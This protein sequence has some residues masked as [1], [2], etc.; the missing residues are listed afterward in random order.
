VLHWRAVPTFDDLRGATLPHGL[1]SGN[2]P[3]VVRRFVLTV[4]EPADALASWGSVGDRCSIGS[5]P[6]NDLVIDHKTVSRFHA[7]I[8]V[9]DGGVHLTDTSSKNG[10]SVDG[11][12]I[13][14]ALL[15]DGSTLRLGAAVLRF[16]LG[17]EQNK[18]PLS[19][20]QAFGRLSGGSIAMRH[21]IAFLERAAGSDAT[22]LI[23]GETGTGKSVAAEAIHQDSVRK[24]Q[25]FVIVDCGAIPANLLES[26]LFGHERGAFTGADTRRIGA[27]EEADGG[28]LFLDE[29]GELPPDLQP[30]LLRALETKTFRRVGQNQYRNTDVRLIAATNRDLRAEV[31]A[32]RFRADLYFRL[33]VVR[34]RMPALRE[35]AEDLPTIAAE[36]L[37]GLCASPA[38]V[39]HLL[40]PAFNANLQRAA[41]PGNVREMRNYLERCLVFEELLPTS[42]L[43]EVGNDER[44]VDPHKAY[45]L[46]R[47]R[48]IAGFERDYVKALLELHGGKVNQAATA[49]GLTRVHLY[50]LMRRHGLTR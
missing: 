37:S 49:A 18:L 32:S 35:R 27:F 10:T 40:T 48:A 21:T 44:A 41:W 8:T 19:T 23:E 6:T 11:V 46:E 15:K 43:L 1:A 45:G 25:P 5:D 33:A 50:R 39:Q 28:T 38:Q 31:N 7:E 16:Q 4:L 26:E 17:S 14:R 29:I 36:I 22:V 47:E 30:K 9:D 3:A 24:G 42:D 34:V 12:R 20:R 2:R 13:E